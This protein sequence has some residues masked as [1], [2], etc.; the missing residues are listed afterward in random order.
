MLRPLSVEEMS[1]ASVLKPVTP[2]MSR[3]LSVIWYLDQEPICDGAPNEGGPFADRD[4][5]QLMLSWWLGTT[6]SVQP[7]ARIFWS[8]PILFAEIL[9]TAI[10]P[11]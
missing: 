4:P 5:V 2:T 1:S 9:A 8:R 6:P 11:L 3:Q 7:V 10:T